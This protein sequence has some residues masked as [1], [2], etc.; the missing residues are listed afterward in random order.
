MKTRL[1]AACVLAGL[2]VAATAHAAVI[3]PLNRDPAGS[4]LND[5][6][7]AAPVGGNPG[8]T[9]GEQRRIAYQFAAD[10]WGAVLQSNVEIRVAASFQPLSCTATAGVLGSAGPWHV[11]REFDNAPLAGAWYH[12][13]LADAFAGEDLAAGEPAPDDID[14][15]SRFNANLGTPGCLQASGW[16]YGLDGNTP[17]GRS[18]SSTW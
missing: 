18:I 4:G 13:A 2:L 1:L 14:I 16:Y 3:T 5:P 11:F 9:I 10:L 12:S 17:G 15:N 7:A 6:T 8:T